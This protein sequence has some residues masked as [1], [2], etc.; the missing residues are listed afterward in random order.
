MDGKW[1]DNWLMIILGEKAVMGNGDLHY[2]WLRQ[3]IFI[4]FV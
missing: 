1:S 2:T 3:Y 4:E